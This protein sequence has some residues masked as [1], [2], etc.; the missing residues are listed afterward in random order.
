MSNKKQCPLC[1]ANE[2]IVWRDKLNNKDVFATV[3]VCGS[4]Y[5]DEGIQMDACKSFGDLLK[6]HREFY[7]ESLSQAGKEL[8]LTKTHLWELE[9]GKSANPGVKILNK[10]RKIYRIPA[11]VL[12]DSF[13]L[14]IAIKHNTI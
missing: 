6:F 13:L 1:Q 8:E 14:E 4:K 3:F 7:G 9:K 11:Q 12:L 10:I 5:A 2:L